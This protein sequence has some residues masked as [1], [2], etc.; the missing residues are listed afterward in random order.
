M[1]D[2]QRLDGQKAATTMDRS[3]RPGGPP[4]PAPL[5]G[6]A[7][8]AGPPT[9]AERS[10]SVLSRPAGPV[11]NTAEQVV[12][13]RA[14]AKVN[15]T[16]A[17]H[18]RRPDGFHEIESWTVPVGLFDELVFKPAAGLTLTVGGNHSNVPAGHSNLACRAAAALAR[19]GDRKA[20]VA[21][22][23]VKRIPTGAGLGGGSSDAAATLL[24]L[25][26]LWRLDWP[27][28]RLMP[29]AARLG[30]DVPMF[31]E[32]GPVVIRGRGEL[33]EPLR[34]GWH[35]WLALVA[36]SYG[37]STASV[38]E[39]WA[40]PR[41]RPMEQQRPWERLPSDARELSAL[42]FNDLEDAAFAGEPRL[43]RLHAALSGLG[44][45]SVRM[46][47]S[48]SCLF[49]IFDSPEEAGDWR[50][51]ALPRLDQGDRIL[52]APTI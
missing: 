5:E 36:P 52:L 20:A 49:A 9:P 51:E 25:N 14:A 24:G 38:Y 33:V 13:R 17:V 39:R 29:I 1:I 23:L 19:S 2:P 3:P 50:R 43:G 48:G 47:G 16:L 31:L 22:E 4:F 26:T 12:R 15:L 40:G 18:S 42:L 46:T 6:A 27:V 34:D 35:G 44:G 41:P 8:R 37:I 45:R 11:P 10:N 21:I 30:S 32:P 7:E 28:E